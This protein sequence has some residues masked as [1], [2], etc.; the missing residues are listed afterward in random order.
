MG[1]TAGASGGDD[2][3][4][5]GTGNDTIYGDAYHQID[6]TSHGGD[7]TIYGGAGND[8]IYGDAINIQGQGG[9]DTIDGGSGADRIYAGSGDDVI[10][11]DQYDTIISGGTGDDTLTL[12]DSTVDLTQFSDIT[13]IDKLNWGE[14]VTDGSVSL[15]Y[16]TV[17]QI[18]DNKTLK[19]D[20]EA[21]DSVNLVDAG[22]SMGSVENGYQAYTNS[23]AKVLVDLGI[24]NASGVDL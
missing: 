13:G 17:V 9:N 14:M 4:Y 15:D 22:W 23:D 5:G 6:S 10:M 16:N 20:G 7:D 2:V 1:I 24:F 8:T 3:I 11:F 18:S 21:G 19:I 12:Q